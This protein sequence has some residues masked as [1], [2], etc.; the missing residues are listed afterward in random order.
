MSDLAEIKLS[1]TKTPSRKSGFISHSEAIDLFNNLQT[2]VEYNQQVTG[3]VVKVYSHQEDLPIRTRKDGVQ[4]PVWVFYG[5]IDVVVKH[6]GAQINGVGP[7][8]SHFNCLPLID[9]EVILVEH[10]EKIYYS[11]PLNS[12]GGVNHNRKRKIVGEKDVVEPLTYYAR[13]V[14]PTHGDT[15]MQGRFGNYINLTSEPEL[16]GKPAY[17]KIII[18]NNQDRDGIQVTHK[19]YDKTM[20]HH[21]AT[22]GVGSC[23]E[24]TSSPTQAEIQPSV[25]ETEEEEFFDTSGDC[26]TITSDRIIM[27]TND[28]AI[29]LHSNDDANITALE[30]LNLVGMGRVSLGKT[31]S[32]IPIVR[33]VEMKA[34]IGGLLDAIINDFCS[35]LEKQPDPEISAVQHIQMETAATALKDKLKSLK[36]TFVEEGKM[37]SKKVFAE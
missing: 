25:I 6:S 26:I 35:V 10:D 21:H 34:L 16:S 28:G 19:N 5:K 18:G 11:F 12:M 13:P 32:T 33:G 7:L 31:D 20:P 29:S 8:C 23:I 17:P 30:S 15:I 4:T 9:E 3:R 27:N 24:I 37:L 1:S 14:V 22:N 36:K 2:N